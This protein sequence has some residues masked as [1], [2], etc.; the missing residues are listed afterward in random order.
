MGNWVHP[1]RARVILFD[2]ADEN[3]KLSVGKRWDKQKEL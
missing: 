2:T 1:E 3:P